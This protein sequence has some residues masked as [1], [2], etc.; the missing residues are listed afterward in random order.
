MKTLLTLLSILIINIQTQF[1]QPRIEVVY[2]KECD[3]VIASDS[4]FIIGNVRP[5]SAQFF[6]NNMP[7]DLHY[8]GTFLAVV[9]VKPGNFTFSCV[10]VFGKDTLKLERNVYIP[11][12]LKTSPN[13]PLSIDT[14]YIFPK[15]TWELPPGDI[16]KVAFKGTPGCDAT[17]SIEG[18]A[19]NLPMTELGPRANNY[20]G[21]ALFGQG[22]NSQMQH[23][24][25]IYIGSYIIQ[26]WDWGIERNI[27]FTLKDDWGN[28]ITSLAPGKLRIDVSRVPKIAQF[29]EKMVV[30]RT[31]P[32]VGHQ[33]HFPENSTVRVTAA[34]ENH[35]R[36]RLTD[37]D[38][39]W[40][41]KEKVKLLPPGLS[42]SEGVITEINTESRDGYSIINVIID[43]RLPFKVEQIPKPN[44]LHI[45]FYN[46][47]ENNPR[48]KINFDDPLFQNINWEKTGKNVYT[49]IIYLNQKRQ[50]GYDPFYQNGNFYIKIKKKPDIAGWPH[51][52]IKNRIICLDPG[53]NPDLGAVGPSGISE[54]EI[55]YEY[56]E[57]LKDALED[58]GAFV[59][60]TH[61]RNDGITLTSRVEF[62]KFIGAEIMLSLHF[63]ALPDGFDPN[64]IRGTS[65][66]YYHPHSY[67]L[68]Y[69]IQKR[70]LK[71]TQLKNFGLFHN[72]LYVCTPPQMISMLAEPAFIIHPEEEMLITNPSFKM[73]VVKAIVKAMEEFLS[74]SR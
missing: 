17:F 74:E 40:I 46:I 63:N 39:F 20:W 18:I 38:E 50:W 62:A 56:C 25:G 73:K 42:E 67:R 58:K 2:P 61:G 72:N 27:K 47:A 65:T 15:K 35:L 22:T 51:S 37:T 59:E 52:P 69:L 64:E 10:S 45:T 5:R 54:K 19:R 33:I 16:F 13:H 43:Q 9:A 6:V 4:T 3:Q 34:R 49:I 53:H 8:N 68:A 31:G 12:Y 66:Y 32:K 44:Q 14:S 71:A 30:S 57:L 29:T 26:S 55:N 60:L 23:V 36:I 28:S 1:A 7:I 48:I 70:I 21:E 11:Y 24:E 41:K